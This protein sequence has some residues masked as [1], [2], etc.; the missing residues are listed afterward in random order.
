MCAEEVTARMKLDELR[1]LLDT[2]TPAEWQ[3]TTARSRTL[4]I[5]G[6]KRGA[7]QS[8]E[9]L[10]VTRSPQEI[11]EQSESVMLA[12]SVVIHSAPDTDLGHSIRLT[13]PRFTTLLASFA[14]SF[15]VSVSTVYLLV[16]I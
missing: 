14:A 8:G 2:M 15:L 4:P 7:T 5:R 12:A 3:T 11:A 1:R 10:V 13:A 6:L 9:F 16:S